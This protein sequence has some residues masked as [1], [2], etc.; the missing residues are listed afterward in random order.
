M[1]QFLHIGL[2]VAAMLPTPAVKAAGDEA[3]LLDLGQALVWCIESGESLPR[4]FDET[5]ACGD[6]GSIW[7]KSN[8]SRNHTLST[9]IHNF[10]RA[11]GEY[12]WAGTYEGGVYYVHNGR[13]CSFHVKYQLDDESVNVEILDYPPKCTGDDIPYSNGNDDRKGFGEYGRAELESNV[14]EL[15]LRQISAAKKAII[16]L[17][18][19]YGEALANGEYDNDPET[20]WNVY[21]V[22]DP[23]TLKLYDL[24]YWHEKDDGSHSVIFG[25]DSTNIIYVYY[26]N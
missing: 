7:D 16:K 25:K 23:D 15:R 24:V 6:A 18:G 1:K 14:S 5:G 3:V 21:T 17:G 8:R 13:S 4:T 11:P 22:M 19:A 26:E 9:M 20:F 10:E 2:T 12:D